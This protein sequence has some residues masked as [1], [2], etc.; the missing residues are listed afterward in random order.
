MEPG[1]QTPPDLYQLKQEVAAI[2]WPQ[3]PDLEN[4]LEQL[5][6][7]PAFV[8][9]KILH[10]IEEVREALAEISTEVKDLQQYVV[11]LV[12]HAAADSATGLSI[13]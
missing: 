1:L 8:D 3:F 12:D 9:H 11:D 5:M 4:Y 10:R 7:H 13:S 6:K 2:H